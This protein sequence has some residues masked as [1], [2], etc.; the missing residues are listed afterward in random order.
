LATTA[1]AKALIGFIE[2]PLAIA[3]PYAL[4]PNVP[5][6]RSAGLRQAFAAAMADPGYKQEIDKQK[7]SYSPKSGE[8]VE[9]TVVKLAQ[10]PAAAIERYREVVGLGGE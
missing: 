3:Y 7:L 6:E 1:E 5:G 9:R 10:A 4:P 8:A 2:V